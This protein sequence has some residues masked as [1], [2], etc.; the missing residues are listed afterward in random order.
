MPEEACTH[1]AVRRQAN[2][3]CL[4]PTPVWRTEASISSAVYLVSS[5][6]TVPGTPEPV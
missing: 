6:S 2:V 5:F 1:I 3:T 4:F